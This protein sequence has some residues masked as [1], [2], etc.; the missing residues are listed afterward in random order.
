MGGFIQVQQPNEQKLQTPRRRRCFDYTKS[1]L[2]TILLSPGAGKVVVSLCLQSYGVA[3]QLW[4]FPLL[5][6]VGYPSLMCK[7]F[8]M[9]T[10]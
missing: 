9:I 1:Y 5:V 7:T 2:N 8:L 6:M 3:A 10:C 4:C